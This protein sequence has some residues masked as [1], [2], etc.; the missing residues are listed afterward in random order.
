MCSNILFTKT[1]KVNVWVSFILWSVFYY[2]K[3]HWNVHDDDDDDYDDDDDD[4]RISFI[5]AWSP[6][7][8]S[9]DA[10]KDA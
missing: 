9:E 2:L 3:M 6:K 10:C 7:T 5:A 1:C 8:A 4:E